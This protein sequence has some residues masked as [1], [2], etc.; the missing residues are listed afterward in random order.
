MEMRRRS[1]FCGAVEWRECLVREG[2]FA[3]EVPREGRVRGERGDGE[4]GFWIR[5]RVGEVEGAWRVGEGKGRGPRMGDIL[6]GEEERRLCVG[7]GMFE[8]W[9]CESRVCEGSRA[10]GSRGGSGKENRKDVGR[11]PLPAVADVGVTAWD[12][13]LVQR[14]GPAKLVGGSEGVMLELSNGGQ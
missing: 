10:G 7:G 1:S 6:F 9:L 14:S 8:G 4:E 12:S 13:C 3:G 5:E 2:L 11:L